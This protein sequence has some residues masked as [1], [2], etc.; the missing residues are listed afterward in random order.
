MACGLLCSD[1]ERLR[2]THP[3]LASVV[4]GSANPAARRRAHARLASAA[5]APDERAAHLDRQRCCCDFGDLLGQHGCA[6]AVLAAHDRAGGRERVHLH[7]LKGLSRPGS[8][9]SA[10]RPTRRSRRWM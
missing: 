6:Y 5:L 1:G 2:F 7:H 9:G 4:Y 3:L 10:P 8:V